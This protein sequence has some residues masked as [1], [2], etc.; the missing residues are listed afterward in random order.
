MI[1]RDKRCT[2]NP[3]WGFHLRMLEV[4]CGMNPSKGPLSIVTGVNCLCL[5]LKSLVI[6]FFAQ[7]SLCPYI[8]PYTVG[9]FLVVP[10]LILFLPIMQRTVSLIKKKFIWSVWTVS[11]DG[12]SF[13]KF[14]SAGA[15]PN[16]HSLGHL[17]F[18]LSCERQATPSRPLSPFFCLRF[19]FRD[20]ETPRQP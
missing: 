13:E 1:Q 16:S 7:L 3:Y 6:M 15:S 18:L 9:S 14:A 4:V 10:D 2:A 12:V 8:C 11:L 19:F 17:Y 5:V 20:V